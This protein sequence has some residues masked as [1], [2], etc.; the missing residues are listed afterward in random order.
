MLKLSK[1]TSLSLL[2]LASEGWR[3]RHS[4]RMLALKDDPRV[5]ETKRFT[6]WGSWIME[7]TVCNLSKSYSC[8]A[9]DITT[10]WLIQLFTHMTQADQISQSAL[11]SINKSLRE[12]RWYPWLPQLSSHWNTNVRLTHSST[13][14]IVLDIYGHVCLWLVVYFTSIYLW[15]DNKGFSFTGK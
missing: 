6:L 2:T 7:P 9:S 4:E 14:A 3:S 1:L 10:V 5:T 11:G 8:C 15:W 13:N 12:S